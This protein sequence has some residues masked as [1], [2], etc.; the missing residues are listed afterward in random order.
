MSREQRGPV[1]TRVRVTVYK[2]PTRGQ[3]S[4]GHGYSQTFLA[5]LLTIS[6]RACGESLG[7]LHAPGLV[8][9]C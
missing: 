3:D 8:L 4:E 5:H 6:S 2:H 1:F 9:L 7:T